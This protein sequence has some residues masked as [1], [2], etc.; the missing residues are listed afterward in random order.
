MSNTDSRWASLWEP[1]SLGGYLLSS[2]SAI[3]LAGLFYWIGIG[4]TDQT[5]TTLSTIQYVGG[6]ILGV[7][8]GAGMF[9]I[10]VRPNLR[11]HWQSSM[12]LR[13]TVALPVGI[14]IG[15]LVSIAPAILSLAVVVAAALFVVGRTYLYITT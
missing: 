5:L 2:G 11:E 13:L 10:H 6:G 8:L 3:V 15:V 12:R 1:R 7:L 9:L 4:T 14:G